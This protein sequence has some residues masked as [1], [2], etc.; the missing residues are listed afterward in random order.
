[1]RAPQRPVQVRASWLDALNRAFSPYDTNPFNIDPLA[2]YPCRQIDFDAVH[3]CQDT[4]LFIAATCDVKR[5]AA[6]RSSSG[7]AVTLDAVRASCHA[8]LHPPGGRD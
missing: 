8:A 6:P 3:A 7:E 5:P 4:Q 1:M 2:T